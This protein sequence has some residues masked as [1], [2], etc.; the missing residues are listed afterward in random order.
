M[1]FLVISEDESRIAKMQL[2]NIAIATPEVTFKFVNPIDGSVEKIYGEIDPHAFKK[3]MTFGKA[4]KQ[5]YIK[6]QRYDTISAE[7][8]DEI[9]GEFA[10]K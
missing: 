3:G 9:C 1:L 6:I 8:I 7:I 5:M 2:A 10:K 4:L